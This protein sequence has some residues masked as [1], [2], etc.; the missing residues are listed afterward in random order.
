MQSLDFIHSYCDKA[1]INDII[2]HGMELGPGI[3]SS[4]VDQYDP[5]RP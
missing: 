4:N 5:V 2:Y 1:V 3:L